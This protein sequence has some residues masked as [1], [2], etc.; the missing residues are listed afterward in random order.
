MEYRAGSATELA[1][2]RYRLAKLAIAAED[3]RQAIRILEDDSQSD[4]V[5]ASALVELRNACDEVRDS[6]AET[7]SRIVKLLNFVA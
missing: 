1:E 2:L 5:V 3:L 4:D 7:D 6:F